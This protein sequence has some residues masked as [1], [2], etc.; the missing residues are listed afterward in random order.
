[1]GV[2]IFVP[3]K[4]FQW[5]NDP[6]VLMVHGV[7]MQLLIGVE[8]EKKKEGRKRKK[9][10]RRKEKRKR[11]KKKRKRKMEKKRRMEER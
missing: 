11:Q 9:K 2:Q 10:E 6:I 7:L 3:T 4:W 5:R 1:M 8:G